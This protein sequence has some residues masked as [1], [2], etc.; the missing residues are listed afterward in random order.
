MKKSILL[1]PV[2]QSIGVFYIGKILT[3]D[4]LDIYFV[5]RRAIDNELGIQ[6]DVSQN[7]LKK[8][9]DYLSEPEAV[10]PTAIIVNFDSNKVNTRK[11]DTK[12]FDFINGFIIDYDSDEKNI[13]EIIDGQHRIMGLEKN[14]DSMKEL[15]IVVFFDLNQEDKAEIFAVIN[16]NQKQVNK[17][18]IYDLFDLYKEKSPTKFCHTIV[19]TLN[20]DKL[21]PLYSRIK[22]IGKKTNINE[23]I[24]QASLI[25]GLKKFIGEESV[26]SFYKLSSDYIFREFYESNN[27]SVVYKILFNYF[28][29]C[30][31]VFFKEWENFDDYILTKTTGIGALLKSLPF[32]Y[33]EGLKYSDLSFFFFLKL[34][35]K[36]RFLLEKEGKI[37][38]RK[39]F[40]VGESAQ[41]DLSN[42][43]IKSWKQ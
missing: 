26:H 31:N 40:G 25:D 22:M 41:K 42:F 30:K 14:P 7:R 33:N 27:E 34:M 28:N 37:F 10:F 11:L 21:S 20:T 1:F 24:S 39:N 4:L 15:P 35:E 13:A 6:R 5:N 17:S 29:A 9:I 2:E 8:I 38:T 36:T 16:S 3:K 19:K 32:A 12:D 43:F 18:L 23:S